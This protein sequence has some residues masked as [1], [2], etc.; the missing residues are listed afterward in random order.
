MAV[1]F[2]IGGTG[3][4]LFS[5]VASEERDA[6]STLFLSTTFRKIVGWTQHEQVLTFE[7]PNFTQHILALFALCIDLVLAR[8][9]KISLFTQFDTRSLQIEPRTFTLARLGYFQK[10]ARRR[11]LDPLGRQIAP[12]T[13]KGTIALHVRGGDLL[14]LQKTGDSTYGVLEENYYHASVASIFLENVPK[15]IIIL[16]DDPE[17]AATFDFSFKGVSEAEIKHEPLKATLEQAVGAEWFVSSNSTMSYWI[18]CLRGGKNS[19]APHPFQK[20]HDY[21]LPTNTQR[22]EVDYK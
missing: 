1:L 7:R 10:A 14:K 11:S 18:V 17:Y 15:R 13:K 12:S 16:T 6:V 20:R 4:Q 9:L 5:Y 3:N 2:L 19:F 22:I 8:L 21:D